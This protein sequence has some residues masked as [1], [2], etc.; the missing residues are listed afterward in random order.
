M[1][2][3]VE[4]SLFRAAPIDECDVGGVAWVEQLKF[5]GLG[6]LITGTSVSAIGVLRGLS[7]NVWWV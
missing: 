4:N 6:I 2:T 7:E 5:F 1:M 3:L